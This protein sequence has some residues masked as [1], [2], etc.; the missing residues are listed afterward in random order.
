M[1]GFALNFF[2]GVC[3]GPRTNAYILCDDPDYDPDRSSGLRSL[4]PAEAYSLHCFFRLKPEFL[5]Q[6]P[7]SKEEK[8]CFFDGLSF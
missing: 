4:F 6:F 8:Q 1:N 3:R 2:P 5:T 7:A